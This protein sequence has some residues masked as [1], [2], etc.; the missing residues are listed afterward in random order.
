MQ[1]P[2]DSVSINHPNEY[3][4][5]SREY[6]NNGKKPPAS[7]SRPTTA[8]PPTVKTE[9][10]ENDEMSEADMSSVMEM[11]DSIDG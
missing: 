6:Y 11:M 9:P 3:F 7:F 5:R 8:A 1:V 10:A 4:Q 2:A